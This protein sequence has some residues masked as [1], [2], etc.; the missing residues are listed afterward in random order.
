M[1]ERLKNPEIMQAIYHELGHLYLVLLFNADFEI[2]KFVA[3]KEY[4]SEVEKE[5][6]WR[7][8]LT[9]NFKYLHNMNSPDVSDKFV[10]ICMAGL[11]NQNL[12]YIDENEFGKKIEEFLVPPFE[13]MNRSGGI[14]DYQIAQPYIAN[15][16]KLLKKHELEYIRE[17]LAFNFSYLSR[18]KVWESIEEFAKIILQKEIMILEEKEILEITKK[19]ELDSYLEKNRAD[20]LKSR[21]PII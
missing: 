9:F 10:C 11:C 8:H 16:G 18:K 13:N 21:Y 12:Y 20:I 6:G 7:A 5:K 2:L 1:K 14:P 19:I 4:L 17:I 15:N 3:D